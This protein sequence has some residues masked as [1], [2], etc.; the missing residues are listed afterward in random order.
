MSTL[1]PAAF[2]GHGNPMNAIEHNRYTD[3]WSN[4][5]TASP[6]P[7]AVLV[8]S[9]HW[10][11]NITA[12]TAM[13]APRTIHDFYGFP[14]PLFDVEYPAPGDPDL[15]ERIVELVEAPVRQELLASADRLRPA[16]LSAM[17]QG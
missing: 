5:A 11:V 9:A 10:F 15:A 1:M 13:R 8:V 7:S 17:I 4:F 12:V 16:I 2:V 14:Q 6:R 3:A